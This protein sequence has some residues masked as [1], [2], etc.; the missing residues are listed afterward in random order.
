M[1]SR[2]AVFEV[3]LA[4]PPAAALVYAVYV[5]LRAN[6]FYAYIV[7]PPMTSFHAWSAICMVLSF[8]VA[9]SR[10]KFRPS[11]LRHIYAYALMITGMLLYELTYAVFAFATDHRY[12]LLPFVFFVWAVIFLM[13]LDKKN[14]FLDWGRVNWAALG[15]LLGCYVVLTVNGFFDVV[16]AYETVGGPDPNVNPVWAVSKF[17]GMVVF[18]TAT[19]RYGGINR[20][21]RITL[22]DTR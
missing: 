2:Y 17:A 9:L 10:L 7:L 20:E 18:S 3:I 19:I 12:S 1:S 4:L 13:W 16:L 11:P 14:L 8:G 5:M 21:V 15:V 6:S 22:D